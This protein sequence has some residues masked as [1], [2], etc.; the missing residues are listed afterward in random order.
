M[1]R[2]IS[3][4]APQAVT[5]AAASTFSAPQ[6][7]VVARQA[8]SAAPAEPTPPQSPLSG[9]VLGVLASLDPLATNGP[10]TPDSPVGLALMAVGARRQFG[11]AG[12]EETAGLGSSPTLT[13][14]SADTVA[15]ADQKTFTAAATPTGQGLDQQ[16]GQTVDPMVTA[17]LNATG[18]QGERQALADTSIMQLSAPV[19]FAAAA[20]ADTTAPTVSLTAPAAGPI[21]G[22]VTMTATAADDVGVAGVQFLVNGA[23]YLA[24][25]TATP[26]T[27]TVNTTPVDNGTYTVAARARDAAGNTATTAAVSITV[28]NTAPTVSLTG[29][30]N[31]ATVSGSVNLAATAADTGGSG[32]AGV[33]FFVDGVLVGAEDTGSPY[34]VSWN[35]ATVGN[36][37]HTV[38]AR[39]RDNAGNTRISAARTVNV[40]NA[41]PDTTAPTVSLTGP[42]NGATVSGSVNLAASAADTGG[43]GMAGVQF[44]V[45]GAAVGAED[46]GSPYGVSW[47]TA[48]VGNGNHTVTARA[49]D[50][51]GNTR[52]SAARTVNVANAVAD[53]TA[54]TVSLTSPAAGPIRGAVTMTATATDNAG[55]SGMA[56]VQFLVNGA[57]VGAEDTATPY[58][59]TVN[60]TAADNGTYTVAARAR[61]G[62]GNTSTTPAVSITVDNSAPTV[63]L[64]GPASGATVSGSV[65]LAAT[66][67][68]T[69]GSGVAG[70]QF[71][72]DGAAQGAE[73]TT[74]PYGMSWDTATVANGTH[75]LAARARDTAGNTTTTAPVSV[76][77]DNTVNRAPMIQGVS[78]YYDPATGR[79]T[80][81]VIA[82]DPD[83][84]PLTYSATGYWVTSTAWGTVSVDPTTGAY[85]YT[86]YIFRTDG[87]GSIA[88]DL[89]FYAS[90]GQA[91]ASM[92]SWVYTFVPEG[93]VL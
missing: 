18:V 44:F 62:A 9:V 14:Q 29:P 69:G 49:R 2:C 71:L 25:D 87:G 76:T 63:S 33:Q 73:V 91:T 4:A 61:D 26:Y 13:S 6:T 60:T 58:T 50:N 48:T 12:A 81:N 30:A 90:D 46:T 20:A 86:P 45:D 93:W 82:T 23:P 40:A 43:S 1:S 5:A 15:A 77:V 35:T 52:I 65:N 84:D 32:M 74:G 22:A 53:T 54:P 79:T 72:V 37:S 34:G 8:I 28:D 66:A 17:D 55:G 7:G 47:N 88:E 31:G 78:G 3:L 56:G 75:T 38:T 70:V 11:Q 64:T 24:E 27:L 83:G 39:A 36:G 85:V 57:A 19:G 68:D 16:T 92:H 51:A 89:M 21:R 42:A 80:G 67:A 10:T 59:L 41:A